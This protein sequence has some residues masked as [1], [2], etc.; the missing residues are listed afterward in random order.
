MREETRWSEEYSSSSSFERAV[1]LVFIFH[2]C[3]TQEKATTCFSSFSIQKRR[4]PPT[5]LLKKVSGGHASN[6]EKKMR[7]FYFKKNYTRDF[8]LTS[9]RNA[10]LSLFKIIIS[11]PL[12]SV[13]QERKKEMKSIMGHSVG[14]V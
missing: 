1:K 10:F 5:F 8:M 13:R 12:Y 3:V 11:K 9:S 6:D 2:P 7:N 14:D 4:S